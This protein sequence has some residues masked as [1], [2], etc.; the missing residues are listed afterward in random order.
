VIDFLGAPKPFCHKTRELPQ[1]CRNGCCQPLTLRSGQGPSSPA[2]LPG[3]LHIPPSPVS[4]ALIRVGPGWRLAS[5]GLAAEGHS[6][7]AGG[8]ISSNGVRDDFFSAFSAI[9]FLSNKTFLRFL[10]KFTAGSACLVSVQM[11][12]TENQS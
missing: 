12:V 4:P 3:L 5:L 9:F 11:K 8:S 6:V 7:T 2:D 1:L 10:S